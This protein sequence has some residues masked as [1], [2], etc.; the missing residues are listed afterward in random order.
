[1]RTNNIVL[2]NGL[3]LTPLSLEGWAHYYLERGYNIFAPG[4]PGME[5]DIRALRRDPQAYARTSLRRIVDHYERLVLELDSPP[6]IIGHCLGGLVTQALLSRGLGLCGIALAPLPVKGVW[7]LP[8]STLRVI[9]PQLI[10]PRNNRRSVAL[11]PAQFHYAMMNDT[12]REESDRVYHRYAVPAA[13]HLLF[14]TE[15]ANFNP[16]AESQVNVRRA[17]RPPL[18]MVAGELDHVAPP[19]VVK[20]NFRLYRHS[21]AITEYREF[22]HRT[23]FLIG[24]R[25][26]GDIADQVIDWA[27]GQQLLRER[28]RRRIAREFKAR[29]VA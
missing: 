18:L 15:L 22:A 4:W 28:E 2:I 23:H 7:R 1:M 6:I 20:A 19:S 17:K 14:Q 8:W 27:R 9:A 3:W 25:G 12:T 26:W 29:N 10:D 16:F 24:Q 21:P 11:T 5:R 13:D